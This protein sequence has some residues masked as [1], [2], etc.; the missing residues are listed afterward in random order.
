MDIRIGDKFIA[1]QI[2]Q[3]IEI[4]DIFEQ[5]KKNGE[6]RKVLRVEIIRNQFPGEHEVFFNLFAPGLMDESCYERFY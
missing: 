4:L 5:P 3:T 2:D 6:F 1:T